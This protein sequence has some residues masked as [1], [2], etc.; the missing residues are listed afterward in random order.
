MRT[1]LNA[2][3]SVTVSL[4]AQ[5]KSPTYT[6]SGS[7]TSITPKDFMTVKN[8]GPYQVSGTV[9]N[10]FVGVYGLN[11]RV[12]WNMTQ[13]TGDAN[14]IALTKDGNTEFSGTLTMIPCKSFDF[15][16]P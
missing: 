12:R 10:W 6:V 8:G 4:C 5:T 13:G 16:I 3:R 7:D 14:A 1:L 2:A 15:A 9:Y 11:G